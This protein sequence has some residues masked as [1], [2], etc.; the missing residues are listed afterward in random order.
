M[1]LNTPNITSVQS[2]YYMV[3]INSAKLRL[4]RE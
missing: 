1:I 2:L 3:T 4:I